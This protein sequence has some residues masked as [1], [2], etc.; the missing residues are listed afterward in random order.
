MAEHDECPSCIGTG[1][2]NPHIERSVCAACRGTG[3]IQPG[4][5]FV[6]EDRWAW[7]HFDPEP[8][9]DACGEEGKTK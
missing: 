2:G 9:D 1:I 8:D 3:R 5:Q 7:N 6:D 4:R